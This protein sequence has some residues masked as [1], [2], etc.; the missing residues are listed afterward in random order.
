MKTDFVTIKLFNL[1]NNFRIPSISSDSKYMTIPVYLFRLFLK[2]MGIEELII[3]VVEGW[4][5]A[6]T[7]GILVLTI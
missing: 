7:V 2:Q 3:V 6:K 4:V 1:N 5:K